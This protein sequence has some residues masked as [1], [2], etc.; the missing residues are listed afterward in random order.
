M[1]SPNELL[2][3]VFANDDSYYCDNLLELDLNQYLWWQLHKAGYKTVYF[4]HGDKNSFAVSS[5]GDL[6]AVPYSET[7]GGFKRLLQSD[8][9]KFGDWMLQRL[10]EKRTERAA[11]VCSMQSFCN[12][13]RGEDWNKILGR[14]A[15][16]EKRT[17]IIVLTA[18]PE[19][20]ESRS[21]LLSSPVFEALNDPAIM[22]LRRDGVQDMYSSLAMRK[23][24]GVTYLNGYTTERMKSM[25]FHVMMQKGFYADNKQLYRCAEYL[26]QY[27]NNPYLKRKD[28]LFGQHLYN[29]YPRYGELHNNTLS[30]KR[31]W[32]MLLGKTKQ[33]FAEGGV[34]EYLEKISCPYVAE[35]DMQ[36]CV[37]RR[38]NSFAGR[39]MKLWPPLDCD[40][41]DAESASESTFSIL[42]DIY[43]E[44]LTPKNRKDNP[45]IAK[46]VNEFLDKLDSAQGRKDYDTYR[47]ALFAIR[48]CVRWLSVP[49]ADEKE[50]DVITFSKSLMQ[51]VESSEEYFETTLQ[52]ARCRALAINNSAAEA[53]LRSFE[54]I[55]RAQ[56]KKLIALEELV[57]ETIIKTEI[58]DSANKIS[59][60]ASNLQERLG[61]FNDDWKDTQTP[62][63]EEESPPIEEHLNKITDEDAEEIELDDITVYDATPPKHRH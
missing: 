59:T 41:R 9:K 28:P 62:D 14:I 16:A 5:F 12:T 51:L 18:S 30:N 6:G 57:T 29:E 31:F 13:A 60:L 4:L 25:L 27:M 38:R 22:N 15:A 23:P 52:L 45:E 58:S 40:V 36:V 39:C 21:L 34:K 53:Q 44:L 2:H 33:V 54:N 19:V 49:P 63:A 61:T 50:R 43:A 32:D 35:S 46:T 55:A 3:L 42:N 10:K 48:F 1:F 26:A 24:D 8:T 17:G 47:R 20:E 11:I 37:L 56:Y 7:G